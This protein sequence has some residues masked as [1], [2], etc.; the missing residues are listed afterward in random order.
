MVDVG[1]LDHEIGGRRLTDIEEV[2]PNLRCR[3]FGHTLVTL[4]EKSFAVEREP[5]RPPPK[6][7]PRCVFIER[8][9]ILHGFDLIVQKVQQC[10]RCK[11]VWCIEIPSYRDPQEISRWECLTL[12]EGCRVIPPPQSEVKHGDR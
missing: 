9:V 7:E 2:K 6:P 8:K 1:Q 5:D 12:G 10:S 4:Q 11:Q 3:F